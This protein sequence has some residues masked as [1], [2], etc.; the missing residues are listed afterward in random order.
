MAGFVK[1]S[2][3]CMLLLS[4]SYPCDGGAKKRLFSNFAKLV[5]N[6]I[7]HSLATDCPVISIKT[8]LK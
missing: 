2:F 1:R 7:S 3:F 4:L 8:Y 6:E 5:V